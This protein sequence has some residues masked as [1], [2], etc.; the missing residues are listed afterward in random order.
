MKRILE[1]QR[2]DVCV[3]IGATKN[4]LYE[5]IK[6]Q[7]EQFESDTKRILKQL[8]DKVGTMEVRDAI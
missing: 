5:A 7:N 2:S 3:L 8:E 1:Q 6:R 4:E